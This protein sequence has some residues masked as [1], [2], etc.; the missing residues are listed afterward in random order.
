MKAR[1]SAQRRK[2]KR[3][4]PKVEGVAREPNGR[5][6]RSGIDHEPANVVALN[7]RMRHRGITEAQARDQ[8][9][10]TFI[11]YL[12]LL[13]PRDGLSTPQ[14]EALVNFLE[15][16]QANLRAI[17]APNAIIDRQTVGNPGDEP[18]DLYIDWCNRTRQNYLECRVAIREAQSEHRSENLWDALNYCVIKDETHSRMI[19]A[20][21]LV[22]NAMA[23]FF[24]T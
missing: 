9:A 19:G 1:A 15:L 14:Y 24:R 12:N 21:R 10:A 17:G 2:S 13:G 18:S 5:I 16:Y 23:R 3:G 8:K 7:A 4:R 6:S 20:L 11:G 22:A